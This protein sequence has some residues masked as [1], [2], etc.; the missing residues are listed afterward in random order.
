MK[1]F[2]NMTNRIISVVEQYEYEEGQNYE[3]TRHGVDCL[4][5]RFYEAKR[6]IIEAMETS[7]KYDGDG[8]IVLSSDVYRKKDEDTIYAFAHEI[9]DLMRFKNEANNYKPRNK[10][11]NYQIGDRVRICNPEGINEYRYGYNSDMISN[12]GKVATI[13]SFDG[14]NR[15]VQCYKLSIDYWTYDE[16]GLMLV[17]A[18][19]ADPDY[20][21]FDQDQIWFFARDLME[22]PQYLD[23]DSTDKVNVIFPCARAHVGQKTSRIIGKICK[24]YKFYK[25]PWYNREFTKFCDA[26]NP[27]A[28]TQWTILSVNPIDYLTMSFGNSWASCHTIDKTNIR[29]MPN[30]YEGMYSGGTLSYMLDSTSIVMYV[31]DGR[32]KGKDYELQPKINRQ[33]FHYG[34]GKLV[35]GRLYP[36][37]NDTGAKDIYDLF[38]SIAQRVIAECFGLDNYWL[39]KKGTEACGAVIRSKGVHYRDYLHYDNCNV[40]FNCHD[41]EE[42]NFHRITVGAP[43]IC[44]ECGETHETQGCIICDSCAHKLYCDNCGDRIYDDERITT[45]SGEGPTF[46]CLYC[47][48]SAG[49]VYCDN[50]NEWRNRNDRDVMFDDYLEEWVYDSYGYFENAV[51]VDGYSFINPEHAI[52]FG[53]RQNDDGEWVTESEVTA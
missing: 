23:K 11:A 25:E 22:M 32:Y 39:N 36:Q 43:E 34:E 53:Y 1:K 10:K 15:G 26:I 41:E 42:K 14:I 8:K 51:Y 46:C 19:K 3:P 17:E 33:M 5:D 38:R 35:Q 9:A 7:P 4:L 6:D 31:V 21:G 28:I 16:R 24:F 47:A 13:T 12:T 52:E 45:Y 30:D 40:S 37:D 27:I 2:E 49:F 18:Y 29:D 50:A 20:V 48:E 44:L